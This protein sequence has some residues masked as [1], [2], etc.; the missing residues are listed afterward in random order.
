MGRS[1]N[2]GVDSQGWKANTWKYFT[3]YSTLV[4]RLL[5][6]KLTSKNLKVY[7]PNAE[8]DNY[9]FWN[10]HS[11]SVNYP[12]YQSSTYGHQIV[13]TP[14]W[15]WLQPNQLYCSICRSIHQSP[16]YNWEGSLLPDIRHWINLKLSEFN[17]SCVSPYNNQTEKLMMT[18]HFGEREIRA[19]LLLPPTST[20]CTSEISKI[21]W[22][23]L[24]QVKECI[25]II[26]QKWNKTTRVLSVFSHL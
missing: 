5:S 24:D 10:I 6:L 9:V 3:T 14:T 12:L 17:Q 22:P 20:I 23:S 19:Y 21:K 2:L 25:N 18:N 4:I 15:L 13:L 26:Q 8:L 11:L 16:K 7:L 1:Q